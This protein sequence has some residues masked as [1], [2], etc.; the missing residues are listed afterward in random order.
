MSWRSKGYHLD[1]FLY[2]FSQMG[3]DNEVK[4]SFYDEPYCT[5]SKTAESKIFFL[6]GDFNSHIASKSDGYG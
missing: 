3:V 5:V 2:L 6:C 1:H 4:D